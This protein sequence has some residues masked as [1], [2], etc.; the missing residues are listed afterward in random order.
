VP[1]ARFELPLRERVRARAETRFFLQRLTRLAIVIVLVL[2]AGTVGLAIAEDVSPWRGFVI[3]LDTVATVGALPEPR[4]TGGQVIT[5]LLIVF[6]V[7]T[8]FYALVTTAEFFVAGHL[9]GL[10]VERR[11]Q[12]LTDALSDHYIVCGFGRVGREVA[13]DLGASG[14]RFV[15]VD[16]RGENRDFVE[17]PRVR[18]IE[19]SPSDDGSL[20][21]AGIER[22][23]GIVACVDSDAENIF[24]TLTARE[25]RP[26]I[27]IIARASAEESEK[28]LRR[29]GADRIVSPYKTSGQTMARLVLHPQVTGAVDVAPSYRMEEIEVSGGCA[30]AGSRLEDVRGDAFVVAI[31]RATGSFQVQPPG[32]TVLAPGDVLVAMGRLETIERLTA[33]FDTNVAPSAQ[34]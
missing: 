3:A 27:T 33:L 12:K 13:R 28:K 31:R 21:A 14:A 4:D 24:I 19:A 23:R 7:G 8:L 29:A 18:F 34:G 17:D 20:H 16:E 26:D 6:G 5:V 2:A 32:E 11:M 9:S 30:A 15:I 22:A 25:L 10:L 1:R